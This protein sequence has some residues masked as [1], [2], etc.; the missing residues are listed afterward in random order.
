[1][2]RIKLI[3]PE[4]TFNGELYADDNIV[5]SYKGRN[6]DINK[7]IFV[8]KNLHNNMYSVRQGG[9]VVAHAERIC[10]SNPRFIVRQRGREMVLKTKQKNIHAF[11]KG[12][13]SGSVYGTTAERNDLPMKIEYNPYK[14]K[15]F[16]CTNLVNEPFKVTECGGVILDESGI[17][18][19]N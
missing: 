12:K 19:A 11:I 8:Y 1:M 2:K 15:S 10:I 4:Y 13:Y 9:L 3:T 7:P 6:I 17:R 5:Y 16:V 18:G 14:Y